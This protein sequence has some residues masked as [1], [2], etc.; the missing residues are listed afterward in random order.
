[1]KNNYIII[2]FL[3]L[4]FYGNAQLIN[5]MRFTPRGKVFAFFVIE[6][7][8]FST[9][10]AGF[11]VRFKDKHCFGIDYT[12]FGW[13][14]QTDGDRTD[15]LGNWEHDIPLYNEYERR[16]YFLFDY[17]YLFGD[18]FDDTR[19]YINSYV[20]YGQYLQWYG[21]YFNPEFFASRPDFLS[22]KTKGNF[23]EFGVGPG[24]KAYFGGSQFGIDISANYAH[25]VNKNSVYESINSFQESK[26]KF[27]RN[28]FYMRINLFYDI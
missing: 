4:G 24:F 12:F 7:A 13:Q 19:F 26:V 15:S 9:G 3:F 28:Y 17:K 8:Y 11:E 5:E 14:Y 16:G 27:S 23:Y 6:D 22:N 21:D 10:T 2:L 25:Q 18:Y 20:K 1:M